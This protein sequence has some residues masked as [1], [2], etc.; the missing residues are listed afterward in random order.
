MPDSSYA[1]RPGRRASLTA[2]LLLAIAICVPIAFGLYAYV[3]AQRSLNLR[4][5]VTDLGGKVEI[6][7][8]A[9]EWLPAS[10]R[11]SD[12]FLRVTE[13]HL[14]S[15]PNFNAGISASIEGYW[16]TSGEP[17]ASHPHVARAIGSVPTLRTLFLDCYRIG[18]D[19]FEQ[20]A[21]LRQVEVL[22]MANTQCTNDSIACLREW[23]R[24]AQLNCFSLRLNDSAVPDLERLH[25]LTYLDISHTQISESG[26]AA[27]AALPELRTLRIIGLDVSPDA[28]ERLRKRHPRLKVEKETLFGNEEIDWELEPPQPSGIMVFPRDGRLQTI[29]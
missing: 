15:F 29:Q 9:P 27:L 19:E 18:D 20:L 11:E 25:T 1:R 28:L 8:T 3:L 12:F 22:S 13:V 7:S 21:S 24:L 26:V 16:I 4:T 2:I 14:G 10:M 5:L 17:P 23:P 6:E